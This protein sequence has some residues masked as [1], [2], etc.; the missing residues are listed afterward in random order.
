MNCRDVGP[1]PVCMPQYSSYDEG[2]HWIYNP[3]F[4]QNILTSDA[5]VE[6]KKVATPS[7]RFTQ[8]KFPKF[9]LSIL[10]MPGT[11]NVPLGDFNIENNKVPCDCSLIKV[12]QH[13]KPKGLKVAKEDQRSICLMGEVRIHTRSRRNRVPYLIFK[14][15]SDRVL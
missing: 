11:Q 3:T 7:F 10:N 13:N 14:N 12:T 15:T 5:V 2:E 6:Y 4:L 8:N 9:D 1:E